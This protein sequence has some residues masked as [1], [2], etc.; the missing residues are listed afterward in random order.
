MGGA[1]PSSVGHRLG[2]V[3]SPMEFTNQE[4][5]WAVYTRGF[6]GSGEGPGSCPMYKQHGLSDK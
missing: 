2:L 5:Y 1:W 4:Y 3:H 6:H